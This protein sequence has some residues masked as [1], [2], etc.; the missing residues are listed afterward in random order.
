MN[1]ERSA[2]L[3]A[4]AWDGSNWLAK[5]SRLTS[6]FFKSG[7]FLNR[8]SNCEEN[9]DV[10]VHTMKAYGGIIGIALDEGECLTSHPGRF[11]P[12][13]EHQYPLNRM[14]GGSQSRDEGF[15]KEKN[16]LALPGFE[17]QTMQ[18]VA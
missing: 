7:K 8:L 4:H 6:V 2:C 14:L 3:H 10:T 17:P 16:L 11:T 5:G 9:T 18:P 1:L 13:K 15:E 12:G